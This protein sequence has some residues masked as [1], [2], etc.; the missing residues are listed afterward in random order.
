[1]AILIIGSGA[2]EHA[3][4]K[5]LKKDNNSLSLYCIGTNKNPGIIELT[6]KLV[7]YKNDDLVIDFCYRN[8]ITMVIIGPEKFLYSGLVDLLEKNNI[9]CIG[10][11]KNLA[12]I[13]TNKNYARKLLHN[14][15]NLRYY[16]PVFKLF[17][18]LNTITEIKSYMEFCKSLDFNYV[19]KPTGLCSGKGVWV[20]KIHFN[21]DFEGLEYSLEMIEN[22]HS[23]LIE[24]KLIG[25]EFT[26]MSYTDGVN[27][28]H[29]PIVKDFKLLNS[30]NS[31]PNTGSMGCI[32]QNS[33]FLNNTELSIAQTINM[34]T[35]DILQQDNNSIY[36]GIIYGSFIRC[37]DGT[38]KII[39]FNAR[40][41]DPE[42]VNILELM[43][44]NLY[45]IYLAILHTSL[46]LVEVR[47]KNTNIISK[48]LV[49]NY[50][51][52]K[53]DKTFNI[54]TQW[55]NKNKNNIICSGMNQM[56]D[57]TIL[58][59][60]SRTL[61]YF[62]TGY[63][64][65]ELS[66]DINKK[67]ISM[68]PD[69]KFREDIGANTISYESS[70]VN[71][72]HANKI[73]KGM[74]PYI[75]RTLNS[76]CLHNKGDFGGI[77][78]LPTHFNDPVLIA[79]IDG[80]GSKTSF[81]QNIID[82][83]AY[84]IAGRD[85]V[86]HSI[87]DILVQ[88]GHPYFFLDYIAC[89]KLNEK[90]ILNSIKGM[91]ELCKKYKCPILGGETAEMPKIYN[92]NELDIAGCIVGIA[93]RDKLINGK[94]SINTGDYIIG[95]PSYGLHTNGYSLIRKLNETKE[96]DKSLQQFL[97]NPHRCYYDEINLLMTN[98]INI[99]G[100]VHITGGG[101]I[102]NPKRVLKNDKTM[103]IEKKYLIYDEFKKIQ[104]LGKLS[105]YEM[106]RTFNCGYGM[107]IILNKNNYI[108]MKKIY[109]ENKIIY[110]P[111][112]YII[113][114]KNDESILFV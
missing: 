7:L 87:N 22:N 37:V 6:E 111:L 38:I 105:N 23:I 54:N 14:N 5:K 62:K 49:P 9:N 113:N 91:S 101:F 72:N 15:S 98:N 84:T 39:E 68:S 74:F 78:E 89:D 32:T 96:F 60:I 70:G 90:S 2:R 11:N 97:S 33:P 42:C 20:S 57:N 67:L 102:D 92:N 85:I 30:G 16:N 81:L 77:I 82:D 114:R 3:I 76:H 69:F 88:G 43:E 65:N 41:G 71:I 73:V 64:L 47:Y 110:Q 55:Y 86:S 93:E 79:S 21:S 10:P 103:I 35:I 19:I 106:Y 44:T 51:P 31:G 4:I 83:E 112:G 53:S 104:T 27:F 12:R 75:T 109:N 46:D 52:N 13:E 80:V 63:D 100:L 59:N 56:V 58:S 94:K 17:N 1:M 61:V 95:L 24:E 48:Y 36:K 107:L 28:S 25:E 66:M 29:M 8:K 45:E 50:Y 26:L 34:K 40:Y 108:K 99:N 18:S